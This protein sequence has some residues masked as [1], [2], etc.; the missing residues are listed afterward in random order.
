MRM[1]YKII[2]C[3]IILLGVLNLFMLI[4]TFYLSGVNIRNETNMSNHSLTKLNPLFSNIILIFDI[5]ENE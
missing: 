4:I 3:F 1:F 5:K 2:G